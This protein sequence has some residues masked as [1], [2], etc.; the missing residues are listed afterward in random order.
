[1]Q[2]PSVRAEI[3]AVNDE[4]L[5]H[6]PDD[7]TV[8]SRYAMLCYSCGQFQEAHKQFEIIGDNLVSTYNF[9]TASMEKAKEEVAGIVGPYK[10]KPAKAGEPPRR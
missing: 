4:Y 6:Y 2:K 10:V 8:R 7:M 5:E 3:K 9:S 1:L